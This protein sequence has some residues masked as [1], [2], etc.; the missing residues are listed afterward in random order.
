MK[1]CLFLENMTTRMFLL[2]NACV[3]GHGIWCY[4]SRKL[5]KKKYFMNA[6]GNDW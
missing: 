1:F 2:Q 3:G 4:E 6:N 5:I